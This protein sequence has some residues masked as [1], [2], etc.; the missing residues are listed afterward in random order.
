MRAARYVPDRVPAS[1]Y[2]VEND[3][4]PPLLDASRDYIPARIYDE[5][6]TIG[7]DSYYPNYDFMAPAQ[8]GV[9]TRNYACIFDTVLA[10]N[11]A[12]VLINVDN[13]D[14]T[15]NAVNTVVN[16]VLRFLEDVGV[17]GRG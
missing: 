13:G 12:N 4:D 2:N 17:H 7:C 15:S 1:W 11:R 5:Y 8:S 6:S 10:V 3:V 14:D 16:M 9:R